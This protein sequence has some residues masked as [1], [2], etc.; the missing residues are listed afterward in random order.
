MWEPGKE[1]RTRC[2][3]SA[4][5]YVTDGG[6]QSPIHGAVLSEMAGWLAHCW[7]KD[8]TSDGANGNADDL[9]PPLP[10][11][12]VSDRVMQAFHC[13]VNA[14]ASKRE[15]VAAAITEYLA[16]QSEASA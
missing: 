8:G 6:G 2:G 11:V 4:R 13:D 1:Y 16:E 7:R 15:R 14:G 5:V 12:V 3:W 9:M 10:P